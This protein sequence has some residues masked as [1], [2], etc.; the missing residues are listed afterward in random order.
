MR[1]KI[2]LCIMMKEMTMFYNAVELKKIQDL[3]K[4]VLGEIIRICEKLNIEYFLVGG[5]CLGAVRH[6]GIIPWDDDI[7]VGMTRDNY[8]RFLREAPKEL[9]D[10]YFLQTPYNEPQFPQG[11]SKVRING[12]KFVEYAVRKNK[13]HHGVFVDIFPLDELPDNEEEELRQYEAFKRWYFLFQY[14]SIGAYGYKPQSITEY[15]KASGLKIVHWCLKLIP[16]R[17]LIRKVDT[18]SNQYNGTGQSGYGSLQYPQ[19]KT[20][21]IR[22]DELRPL[23][24]VSFDGLRVKIPENYDAY[25]RRMYGNYMELPPE[26]QRVGHRPYEINLGS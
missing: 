21:Y 14:K 19:R 20:F 17:F 24:E 5:S 2:A 7:D 22:K 26:N 9:P 1:R 3:E 15:V 13:M 16:Q 25:L 10:R 6:G 12:T 11:F 23:M 18:I 8:D 4:E